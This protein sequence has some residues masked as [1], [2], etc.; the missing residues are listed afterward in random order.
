MKNNVFLQTFSKLFLLSRGNHFRMLS[1][2]LNNRL[3]VLFFDVLILDIIVF[4]S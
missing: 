2:V 4:W 3:M 1:S